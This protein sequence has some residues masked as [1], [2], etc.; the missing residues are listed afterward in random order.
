MANGRQNA[1]NAQAMAEY[2]AAVERVNQTNR[3]TAHNFNTQVLEVQD[4]I[5]EQIYKFKAAELERNRK[6][7]VG[8]ALKKKRANEGKFATSGGNLSPDVLAAMNQEQQHAINFLHTS[9]ESKKE[10]LAFERDV[11]KLSLDIQ[12]KQRAFQAAVGR[13]AS[14][15]RAEGHI[16]QGNMQAD[17]YRRQGTAALFQGFSS[18][19]RTATNAGWFDPVLT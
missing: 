3:E 14:D 9:Y 8:N 4:E 7:E 1:R 6:Y 16:I 18:A 5:D 17:N 10:M 11:D 13:T 19:A 15:A 2:N 12:N